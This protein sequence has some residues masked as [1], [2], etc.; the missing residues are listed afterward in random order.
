[1]NTLWNTIKAKG[2][3]FFGSEDRIQTDPKHLYAMLNSEKLKTSFYTYLLFIR[4]ILDDKFY[5][6][7][8]KDNELARYNLL[9]NLGYIDR[10]EELALIYKK[11]NQTLSSED[12]KNIQAYFGNATL[13]TQ[14]Q[15]YS[16]V[17]KRVKEKI[18][19][20]SKLID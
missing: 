1:M 10:F 8:N 20:Q 5:T 13:T 14:E 18:E 19:H 17:E 15:I 4:E 7:Q 6:L 16:Y 3:W 9:Y 11:Q 2:F 12:I